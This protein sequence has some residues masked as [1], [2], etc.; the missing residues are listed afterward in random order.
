[1]KKLDERSIKERL[2][3]LDG[4]DYK[5]NAI[6]TSF[7]F[8]NFKEAFATMTR[9]AFEAELQQHHPEWTNV[10]NTLNISLSTHDAGGLT[11]KDFKLAHTIE[12]LLG[13]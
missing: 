9:I 13:N 7:E 5:D 10:Y 8:E 1:M 6:H 3:K 12:A 4:W 11:E 2:D